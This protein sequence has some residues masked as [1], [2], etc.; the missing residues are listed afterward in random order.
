MDVPLSWQSSHVITSALAELRSGVDLGE[1]LVTTASIGHGPFSGLA[2]SLRP[3]RVKS[4]V[5]LGATV[6]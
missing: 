3:K 1:V 4:W 6:R 2:V 5:S